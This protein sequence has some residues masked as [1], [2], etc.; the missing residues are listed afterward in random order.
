MTRPRAK[1]GDLLLPRANSTSAASRKPVS[2]YDRE[3]GYGYGGGGWHD[4]P[5]ESHSTFNAEEEEEEVDDQEWGLDKGMELFEVSA[6]DDLGIRHLFD[7]LIQ[8]IIARKDSIEQENEI[9]K[10]ESVFLTD[11][12]PAWAAQAD[13]EEAREKARQAVGMSWNCCQT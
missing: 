2:P 8:A 5:T 11:N 7:T 4:F 6:K 3:F 9:K 10:R 13:A 12:T 1:S